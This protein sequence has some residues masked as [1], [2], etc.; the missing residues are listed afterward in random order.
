MSG[1][2]TDT[3]LPSRRVTRVLQKII[4]Q[5]GA[6]QF[7][8][9][10]NGP[11][12]SSRHYLAWCIE[13]NIGTIHIQPGKPTRNG[14]IESFHG[15]LRDECLNASWFWNLWDAGR[16]IAAWRIEYNTT[17]P[18]SSLGYRTPA[19]FAHQAA[20]PSSLSCNAWPN[21]PQGQALRAPATTLTR[22]RP[23]EKRNYQEGEAENHA[24]YV[25]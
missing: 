6:P 7:L 24:A 19:E 18:H 21:S 16:K 3:S 4:S 20:S 15:C 14:H 9:S 8:P 1:V 23:C 22:A 13:R 12:V 11:E 2:E 25:V 5:R 10:D 17:R